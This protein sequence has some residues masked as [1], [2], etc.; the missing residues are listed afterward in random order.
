MPP[1][2]H[3]KYRHT[4]HRRIAGRLTSLLFF[5]ICLFFARIAFI[6]RLICLLIVIG[7]HQFH[8][9]RLNCFLSTSH[10]H[11][12]C[13]AN[14]RFEFFIRWIFDNFSNRF[15]YGC[16]MFHL[17]FTMCTFIVRQLPLTI[18]WSHDWYKIDCTCL[19]FFLFLKMNGTGEMT[20]IN[21]AF[22]C[23]CIDKDGLISHNISG[24]HLIPVHCILT[25]ACAAL[26]MCV[27]RYI[28]VT[29]HEEQ[30]LYAT[31]P[32]NDWHSQLYT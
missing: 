25:S 13:M 18:I 12:Q 15:A 7:L 9:F 2:C 19:L 8:C 17:I 5:V 30:S 6:A 16:K 22:V 26:C 1:L 11:I 21:C 29:V 23:A 20:L 3:T 32:L 4:H 28:K 24:K 27:C 31:H 10:F 14:I